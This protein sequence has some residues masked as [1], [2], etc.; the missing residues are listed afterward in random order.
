MDIIKLHGA[1]LDRFVPDEKLGHDFYRAGNLVLA[2]PNQTVR[3][4]LEG[5]DICRPC[6]AYRN[7]CQ[8]AVPHIPGITS[9][10][11]YN[12]LLDSRIFSFFD[13]GPGA[14]TALE[15]CSILYEG[16]SNIFHVWQEEDGPAVQKRYELFSA[17]A[18]KYLAQGEK[19]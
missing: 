1:G 11:A 2:D 16:R 3:L 5:D 9:K 14:Y 8:D 10:D 13:L 12:R 17:G 7:G 18:E 6:S 15:L 19:G 4:T